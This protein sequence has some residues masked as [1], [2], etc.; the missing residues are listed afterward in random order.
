MRRAIIDEISGEV[1]PLDADE[2][3]AHEE[4]RH[5]EAS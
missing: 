3:L 1:K 5:T 2:G 4:T